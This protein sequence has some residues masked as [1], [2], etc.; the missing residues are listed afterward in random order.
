MR[1]GAE[2]V[3]KSAT[4]F[5]NVLGPVVLKAR[6]IKAVF[7]KRRYAADSRR[8]A[9]DEASVLKSLGNDDLYTVLLSPVKARVT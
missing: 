2:S 5:V 9:V 7:R 6:E 8:E 4:V 3:K 1:V